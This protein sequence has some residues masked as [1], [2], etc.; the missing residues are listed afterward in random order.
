MNE[1]Q[2]ICYYNALHVRS[3][4]KDRIDQAPFNCKQHHILKFI[5][6]KTQTND[7]IRNTRTAI[8]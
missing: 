3:F 7:E 5:N 4:F 1:F 6:S 2:I 8:S